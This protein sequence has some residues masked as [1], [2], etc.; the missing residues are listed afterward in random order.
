[1]DKVALTMIIAGS[2]NPESIRRCLTSVGKNV[3]GIFITITTPTDGKKLE[4]VCK[5][6]GAI[7]D[8]KPFSF[9]TEV[10]EDDVTWLAEFMGSKPEVKAHDKV[11][12]FDKAR[13]HSMSLVPKD[14]DWFIWMDAD[15]VWRGAENI[16]EL[17]AFAKTNKADAVFLNYIYQAEIVEGKLRNVV[18]QH[19][20]ER[21]LKNDGSYEW[22]A[23]IHETLI[24]KK[25][26]IKVDSQLCD[27]LHLSTEE[28]RKDALLRNIKTLELSIRQTKGADPRPV[29][30]LAK[31]YFDCLLQLGKPEYLQKA[32]KLFEIY[33]LGSAD[34]NYQN[35]SGW[36]EERAQCWEYLVEIYRQLGEYNNA[37][38][39]GHNAL[40]ED[41]RF[42]SIYVNMAL[43]YLMKNEYGRALFWIKL[44]ARVEQPK[45]T[46]ISNPRDLAART[47]E[48]I[49]HACLQ[50]S[51]LD[52][53]WAAAQKLLEIFPDSEDIKERA[54]FTNGLRQQRE[55]TKMTTQLAQYLAKSGEQHKIVPLL[56][57][58]PALIE[59]NPIITQMKNQFIPPRVW[60]EDEVAIYCGP[61]FTTWSPETIKGT[62]PMEFVGGSEEAVIYLSKELALQGWKVTV[63]ADPGRNEGVHDGVTYLPYHKFNQRDQFNIVVAWRRPSFVDQN[64]SAN[65]IFI[66]CHDIQNQL[67]YTEERLAKITK[68]MVLSPWHRGNIPNVPD[69]K[70]MITANGITI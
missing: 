30:Y 39:A 51:Q 12:C 6:F 26:T 54:K 8:Y 66:W 63:Y 60:G 19:L 47:L 34:Y 49:Y 16:K 22:V 64:I 40:I 37:I 2:E 52:E 36:G 44:G 21:L 43:S 7:V 58:T 13:N 24:E 15:D 61:G 41:E 29:Y 20:R 25:P 50:T 45:T 4:K 35:K 28:R 17:I 46:L 55:L 53:A 27:V 69:E 68:V 5:E 33:L 3:D 57:S 70:I 65:K 59:D 67:D 9:F 38:K 18:I 1:M 32:K 48:V 10:G 56:L 23:P 14:Y 31:A 42:P 11:F 62:N